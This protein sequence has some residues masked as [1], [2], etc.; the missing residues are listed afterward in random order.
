MRKTILLLSVLATTQL[1]VMAQGGHKQITLDDIYKNGTFRMKGVPGFNAMK[2]GK[3]YTQIDREGERIR[4]NVYDLATGKKEGT[5]FDNKVDKFSGTEL[6][7]ESY[8][9]SKDERKMLLVT[10]GEHIYR[11]SELQRVYVY[12]IESGTIKLL[13]YDKVLHATFSP[14]GT[15]VAF[16]KNN[17]LFYKDVEK[18]MVVPVTSDGAK[19]RIINGNC[20]WVYEEEFSFT[21]AFQ[22]SENSKYL[23]YYRFDETLVPEYTMAKYTG[24]YP[25]QYTYKYPKAGERNS[26]V[27]I[28]IYNLQ[29]K[30]TITANTGSET[31]QYLPRIKWAGDA[32]KLCI[33]RLNRR[34]N[35]LDMILADA[36]TGKSAYIYREQNKAY[37]EIEDDITFLKD[38]HS[39]IM[40]SERNGYKHL[41]HWDWSTQQL[42]DLTKGNF[43]VESLTGVDTKRGLVFYTAADRSPLQ[44]QLYVTN[45]TG[46]Y[47]RCLT[48]EAGT[49]AITPCEGN[50]YFLDRYSSLN[51]VPVYYLRDASGRIIRTL[52][53]NH[54][55]DAKLHEYDLG[56]LKLIKIGGVNA[57]LN[58]WMMT[59]PD[60]D[61]A[62]KYPVLMFQYSGPGSQQV[63][64]KWPIG[65]YFWHQMMAQKGYI[66]VCADGTG[67]GFRGEAFR[68][69][70][71]L[72]LGKYESDDQIAVAKSLAKLPYVDKN[73]IGIWGWSYGGFMS[74][75][76]ILKGNDVFKAAVSVAPV[77]N[78]RFYDNVY[79]ERYMRLPQENPK[80][81]DDNAPE[82]MADRLKGKLLLM[83]GTGDDNV[84]FQNA[85]VFTN[86][87][88]KA[89]KQFDNGYYPDRA[90]GISGGNATM[91]LYT[92]MTNFILDNL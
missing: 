60:F 34:Q 21:R 36:T 41:Y 3:R 33:Y 77:T 13:D 87:L 90:H 53:D 16:V 78:W 82:K 15:K 50:N 76:C 48:P 17:N 47:K 85:A 75:T 49:H 29:S 79:T 80:G 89:N 58:A 39:M 18:D 20:D 38:G 61:P 4:I 43:D 64:D 73:R 1:P 24:L 52:E 65:N 25:E 63:A 32:N 84:H 8:E 11:H 40:G 83:H 7:I 56:N 57:Q 81:Y 10:D 22:W 28:K 54:E 19:N 46:D 6:N 44:R 31:D 42:T 91:H 71:Y 68:K 66:V 51:K 72:Q 5:L 9:L 30:S 74:A 59:P 69:K 45:Y 70:T 86:A 35:K 2:D 62:K 92:K 12:D 27:Q 26:I 23:A 67:T 55:L 37:I 14:D 88:I